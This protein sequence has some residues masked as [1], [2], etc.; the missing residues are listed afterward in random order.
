MM[1]DDFEFPDIPRNGHFCLGWSLAT[2]LSLLVWAF[3][4]WMIFWIFVRGD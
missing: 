2:I 3:I 4:L 1:R